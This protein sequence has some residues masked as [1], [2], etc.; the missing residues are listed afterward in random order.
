MKTIN[1]RNLF[2]GVFAVASLA[3]AGCGSS[4]SCS[5]KSPCSA[6]PAPDQTSIDACNTALNDS[7]CG[8]AFKTLGQCEKDNA[9]C[10]SDNHLD[11]MATGSACATQLTAYTSC[12]T[13]S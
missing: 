9:K 10:T 4:F 12:I 6:D 13:G 8:S 3:L 7:K 5:D 2:V 11:A 1:L